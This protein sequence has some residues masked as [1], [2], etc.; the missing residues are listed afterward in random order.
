MCHSCTHTCYV[1]YT[2]T[3]THTHTY[4]HTISSYTFKALGAGFYGLRNAKDFRQT[5]TDVI[6]QAGDADRWAAN[7]DS[8]ASF[9]AHAQLFVM[10]LQYV[11]RGAGN[12]ATDSWYIARGLHAVEL[13]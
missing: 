6:M 5:I 7:T 3:H 11:L 8:L 9:P 13:E 4:T 2:H 12:E 10:H 1:L